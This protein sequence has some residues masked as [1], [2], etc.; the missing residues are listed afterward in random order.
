MAYPVNMTTDSNIDHYA[1]RKRTCI[2][3]AMGSGLIGACAGGYINSK[4]IKPQ[5]LSK[6]MLESIRKKYNEIASKGFKNSCA[7]ITKT[8]QELADNVDINETK[9]KLTELMEKVKSFITIDDTSTIKNKITELW[10]DTA[11]K[12]VTKEGREDLFRIL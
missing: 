2:P 9:S 3:V 4:N 1:S 8:I 5:N 11:K 6:S 7:E 12:F 10:D